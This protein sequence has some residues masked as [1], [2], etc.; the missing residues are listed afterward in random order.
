MG[1]SGGYLDKNDLQ[2]LEQMARE[3]L[4][5]AARPAKRNVFISF[6]SEDINEVN[7]LRG[8]AQNENSMLEFNDWS[9]KEPFNSSNAEYIKRGIRERIKQSSVTICYV[10]ENTGKSDWVDWEVKESL[11]LGKGVIAVHKNDSPPRNLPKIIKEKNI[12]V[13]PWNQELITNEIDKAAKNK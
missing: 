13:M 2:A 7:L 1:G 12:K 10:T 3:S 5:P 6:A 4:K 8:Q 11:K 9:L